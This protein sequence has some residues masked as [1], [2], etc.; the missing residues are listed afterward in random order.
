MKLTQR[1]LV[2]KETFSLVEISFYCCEAMA[3][4]Q[5]KAPETGTVANSYIIRPNFLNK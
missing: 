1:K 5:E 3:A 2:V 4:V